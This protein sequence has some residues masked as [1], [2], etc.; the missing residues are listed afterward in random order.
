MVAALRSVR[1]RAWGDSPYLAARRQELKAEQQQQGGGFVPDLE[2]LVV[3]VCGPPR[4]WLANA[5]R[6]FGSG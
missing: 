3:Q 4:Q 6:S 5:G 1:S 2:G